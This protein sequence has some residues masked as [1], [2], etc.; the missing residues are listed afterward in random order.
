[1]TSYYSLLVEQGRAPS[2]QGDVVTPQDGSAPLLWWKESGNKYR[3]ITGDLRAGT[4]TG[5]QLT[6][7]I[8]AHWAKSAAFLLGSRTSRT[9]PDPP[10]EIWR[11]SGGSQVS[12]G[13]E[14]DL[15]CIQRYRKGL[16]RTT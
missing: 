16:D 8:I 10:A 13:N 9:S 4:L 6:R 14:K 3:V 1:M 11:F 2:Y 12:K 5:E 7:I 15:R